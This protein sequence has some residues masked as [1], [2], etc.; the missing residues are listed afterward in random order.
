VRLLLNE[1]INPRV[2]IEL[3]NKGHDAITPNELGTRGA[4]DSEQLTVAASE[5]R[6]LV[7]YNI[8]DF[9][10]LL[11]EWTRRSLPHW[12]IIFVSEKTISQRSVGPLVK[13]LHLLLKD[14]P[15]EDALHNQAVHLTK[16]KRRA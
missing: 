13:T 2:A 4:S 16:E 10:R 15:A 14:F 6:A 3:R 11:I 9:K 12:G 8:G 1:Q 5:R 7:T